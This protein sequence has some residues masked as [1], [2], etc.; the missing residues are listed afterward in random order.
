MCVWTPPRLSNGALMPARPRARGRDRLAGRSATR[1]RSA[2]SPSA[3]SWPLCRTMIRSASSRTT[4]ILCSTRRIV[5][6]ASLFRRWIK[7]RITGTSAALMP[8]VGSSNMKTLGSSAISIAT[9]SFLW[10]PCGRLLAAASARSSRRTSA[11]SARARASVSLRSSQTENRSRPSRRR[12]CTA[13]RTFSTTLRLGNSC[14]SWNARPRP[15]W[16]RAGTVS[17]VMSTPS[18]QTEPALA[19]SWPEIRLK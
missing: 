12:D 3:T 2:G 18:N 19:R 5:F 7:S 1:S 13:R 6:V 11:T 17:P 4:S 14:V 10:S 8:A 16:V 9:S 15:R